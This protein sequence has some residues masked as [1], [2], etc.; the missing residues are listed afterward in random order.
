M[1]RS[2]PSTPSTPSTRRPLA[3]G[4]RRAC[5]VLLVLAAVAGVSGVAGLWGCGAAQR[6]PEPLDEAVRLYNDGLRWQR[7]DEA[8]SRLPA[9][10]RDDFLDQRDQLHDDLRIS[11]YDVIRVRYDGKQRRA[12]VQVKYTWYLESRGVV[13]ETHAVQTWHRGDEIWV[14]RS[15]RH[16]RGEVMPGLEGSDEETSPDVEPQATPKAQPEATT[17]APPSAEPG[18]RRDDPGEDPVA[19]EEDPAEPP[20]GS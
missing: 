9:D 3:P 15:E 14:L 7:F 1:M 20:Q 8:A 12:K 19:P 18:P 10:R 5:A 6:E 2:T 4:P 11:E 17:G 13:H 16:L